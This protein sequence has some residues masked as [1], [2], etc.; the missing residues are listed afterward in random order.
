MSS[1][2]MPYDGGEAMDSEA[3]NRLAAAQIELVQALVGQGPVPAGFDVSRV[4]ACERSL[5]NKRRQS[6]GRAWPAIAGSLGA[7][8]LD[9]FTRYAQARPLPPS[10]SALLDGRVFL[11]WLDAASL[12]TDKMRIERL[13][14]DLH[15]V[16]TPIGPRRRHG[17]ALKTAKLRETPTRLIAAHVPWLGERWWRIPTK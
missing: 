9:H 15:Y 3:R 14:F 17:F 12:L 8:Y 16:I 5:L 6:L 7:A 11:D 4:R 1:R 10:G 13:T 2:I